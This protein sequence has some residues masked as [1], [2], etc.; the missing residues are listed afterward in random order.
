MEP[1]P[2]DALLAEYVRLEAE[3][4][5]LESMPFIAVT[6][7]IDDRCQTIADR[8]G[9]IEVTVYRTPARTVRDMMLKLQFM[10]RNSD[11]FLP[12]DLKIEDAYSVPYVEGHGLLGIAIAGLWADAERLSAPEA[13]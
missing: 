11:T 13:D 2:L 1:S 12:E 8:Q 5:Q 6:P 3:L 10:V 9:D 7:D 4:K